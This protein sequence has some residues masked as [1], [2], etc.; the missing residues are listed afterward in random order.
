MP[1]WRLSAIYFVYFGII[2]AIAPYWSLYLSSLGFSAIKIGILASIPLFVRLV[3][4]NFW[5]H[6]ADKTG[7]RVR[8]LRIGAIGSFVAFAL[9]IFVQDFYL[10][11]LAIAL[12]SFFWNAIMGQVDTIT[13]HCLK[14]R[15][16]QYGR[17]RLWGSLGFVAVVLVLGW[18]FDT[19]PIAHLPRLIELLLGVLLATAFLLRSNVEKRDDTGKH[20]SEFIR[21]LCSKEVIVFFVATFLL[22]ASHGAY[23]VFYSI[24]LEEAGYS[25]I[26]IGVYW[27]VGVLAEIILFVFIHRLLANVSLW[28]LF[29]VSLLLT[30]LRW[31]GV[32]YLVDQPALLL[33]LQLLH[34]FS[35][36][37]THAVAIEF[38][39]R[40]FS[41]GMLSRGQAFYSSISFGAGSGFGALMS[42]F[43]WDQAS[44]LT[45]VMASIFAFIAFVLVFVFIRPKHPES[46]LGRQL[47]VSQN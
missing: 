19:F 9:L 26:D 10:I 31:L 33:L 3:V 27:T 25:R 7:R 35:F 41:K 43:I 4:P 32:A 38:C 39:R 29:S 11:A 21:V 42:G 34:A 47:V 13:L 12:Y 44:N 17:V 20:Y 2:G 5:G 8:L 24:Y 15:F 22:H 36:G 1:Y 14:E 30:S 40:R 46:C 18:Y 23:Y 28:L 16:A 6:L 45:F 37:V